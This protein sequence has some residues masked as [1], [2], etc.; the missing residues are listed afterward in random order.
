[1]KKLLVVLMIVLLFTA[2]IFC[3]D[4]KFSKGD[5]YITPQVAFYPEAPNFGISAEYALSDNFSL[6][7]ALFYASWSG[8]TG[9]LFEIKEKIYSAA[10]EAA[11]H[12][13]LPLPNTDVYAGAGV[14]FMNCS[15]TWTEL[16]AGLEEK[17]SDTKINLTPFVGGRYYLTPNIAIN[18]R[19]EYRTAELF[20]SFA[21]STG[22]SIKIK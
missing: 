10:V 13:D 20:D 9:L 19:A 3:D 18:V 2:S 7:L 1:M 5:I 6:A 17:V 15:L 21:L 22:V 8:D 16:A 12:F 4:K 14:G 11:Y